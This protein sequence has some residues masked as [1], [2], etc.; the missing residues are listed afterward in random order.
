MPYV[1]VTQN[2]LACPHDVAQGEGQ[3]EATLVKAV[4][5]TEPALAAPDAV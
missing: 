4:R 1:P 5:N 3:E 2:S